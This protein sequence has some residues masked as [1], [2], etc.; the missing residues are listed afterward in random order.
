[1]RHR[2]P[3]KCQIPGC[4]RT[5]GFSTTNDLGRHIR[6]KHAEKTSAKTGD[7]PPFH[8]NAPQTPSVVSAK[9]AAFATPLTSDLSAELEQTQQS[10][11]DK[12]PIN[13]DTTSVF[14]WEETF[15]TYSESIKLLEQRLEKICREGKWRNEFNP[16]TWSILTS[17]SPRKH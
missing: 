1:M 2:K 16:R 12:A 8:P 4:L 9:V 5:D 3:F 14:S 11:R 6:S 17:L 10:V 15:E 13:E 7:K